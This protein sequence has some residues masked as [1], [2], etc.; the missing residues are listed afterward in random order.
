[1]SEQMR[2]WLS[3]LP[4]V[5]ITV[6]LIDCLNDRDDIWAAIGAATLSYSLWDAW[7]RW[8]PTPLS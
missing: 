7:R 5:F 1:M 4:I 8:R 2:K 6:F 3:L